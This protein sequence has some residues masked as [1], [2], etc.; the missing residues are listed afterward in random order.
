MLLKRSA[1]R[2]RSK[3]EIKEAK[4]KE[5]KEKRLLADKLTEVSDLKQEIVTMNQAAQNYEEMIGQVQ[6]L[7]NQGLLK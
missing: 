7:I 1:Q 2:R 6:G 3:Q 4:L 5:A